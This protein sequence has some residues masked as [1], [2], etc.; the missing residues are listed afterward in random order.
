MCQKSLYCN[1]LSADQ[2]TQLA[3]PSYKAR[4]DKKTET[5]QLVEPGSV[6]DEGAA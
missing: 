6:T 2:K 5:P 1:T 4:K 3:T